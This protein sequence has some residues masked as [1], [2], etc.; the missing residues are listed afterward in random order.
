MLLMPAPDTCHIVDA[1]VLQAF[2]TREAE[3]H[4]VR[5]GS[6]ST[7]SIHLALSIESIWL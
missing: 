5:D 3:R 2:L 4:R 7:Q 1:T 6:M